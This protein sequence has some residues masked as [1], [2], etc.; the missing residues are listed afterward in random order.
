MLRTKYQY[1]L[2]S[3]KQFSRHG[4]AFV[5]GFAGDDEGPELCCG[6][7]AEV[8]GG[9]EGIWGERKG[10]T[11]Y[12]GRVK[13]HQH[14][15]VFH[16]FPPRNFSRRNSRSPSFLDR[17]MES[18]SPSFQSPGRLEQLRK[19]ARLLEHSIERGLN[20]FNRKLLLLKASGSA[21]I[22]G[23]GGGSSSS[24]EQQPL[25]QPD[26]FADAEAAAADIEHE[27]QVIFSPPP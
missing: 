12:I 10:S 17:R 1:S 24:V 9:G 6:G 8:G 23:S 15:A 7:G 16:L 18:P 21:L 19:D 27:L 2:M 22:G 4:L 20:D 25:M 13:K 5:H 14:P 3:R 26:A 11:R